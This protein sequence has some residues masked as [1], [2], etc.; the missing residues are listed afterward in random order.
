MATKSKGIGRGKGGGRPRKVS[1]IEVE[2]KSPEVT[3]AD[4]SSLKASDL[5]G[6]ALSTLKAVMDFSL[7]DGARVAAAKEVLAQAKAEELSGSPEGKKAQAK[8]SA[9]ALMSGGG[10]FSAPSS[11]P[12]LVS[13]T[14]Q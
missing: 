1:A 13:K 3:L 11:P 5:K 14:V 2:S 6:A 12:S 8:Q 9:E 7:Q 10:K 4:V